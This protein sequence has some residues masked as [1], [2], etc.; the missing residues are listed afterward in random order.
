MEHGELP[1]VIRGIKLV[2]LPVDNS[3]TWLLSAVMFYTHCGKKKY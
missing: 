2:C 1:L 3:N